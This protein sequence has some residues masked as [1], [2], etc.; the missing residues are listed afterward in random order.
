MDKSGTLVGLYQP[1]PNMRRLT[2]F[3]MVTAL[4]L[5]CEKCNP[6]LENTPPIIKSIIADPDSVFP[7]DTVQ[8]SFDYSDAEGD[9]I[10]IHWTSLVGTFAPDPFN[11]TG[12][13]IAPKI[14]GDYVIQLRISDKTDDLG[15]VDSIKI[16]VI[17]RPGTFTDL[18]DGHTY[19]WVKIGNQTW[20]A[21]NLAFLPWVTSLLG[22]PSG[23]YINGYGGAST[24]EPKQTSNYKK[25]GVLYGR[26][27]AQ[28]ACPAGW[29]LSTDEEWKT[30]EIFLGMDPA[31]AELF[32]RGDGNSRSVAMSLMS[33]ILWSGNNSCGFNAVPG[34]LIEYIS[35]SGSNLDGKWSFSTAGMSAG[36]LSPTNILS[37]NR[38]IY[39]YENYG[40]SY[41]GVDRRSN[42]DL[43]GFSVCCLKDEN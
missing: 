43:E 12:R 36:Y 4:V 3:L 41:I 29:H 14:P 39:A 42:D 32:N 23:Y 13:W 1:N 37:L 16:V 33:D 22:N 11:R 31:I 35:R 18:R 34:G 7:G 5:F 10:E 28:R 19:K 2:L 20:M 15:D 17:D 40:I 38:S 6:T 24:I 27:S 26:E 25:Y 30:L 8:L 9:S 21:E